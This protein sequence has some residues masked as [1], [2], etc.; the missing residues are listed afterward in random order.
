MEAQYTH[1]VLICA[2]GGCVSSACADVRDAARA[3][4]TEMGLEASVPVDE[5]GCMGLCAIG[6]VMLI[7]P[8]RTFY[9]GLNAQKAAEIIEKHVGGG[10]VVEKYTYFD[11]LKLRHIPC[12]DEIDFY[13]DQVR[14]ALRNCGIMPFGDIEAYIARDG[15]KAL[16]QALTGKTPQDVIDIVK[17]SGLRGRGGAG[18]PT[19]LKWQTAH[20]AR[21][22]TKY[23]VCNA[24]EGDP[25]AFMDRSIL[26]GDPHTVL[27]GML[28]AGYASGARH[29][30]VYV[31]AEYPI[32]I[33]RLT[34]A[35]EQARALGLLG[36]DLFG[37]GFSFDV[38]IRIGAGAFVC[39]EETALMA[40]IESQRG[41]PRQ[42]PPYPSQEGLYGC[43]TIINNVETLAVVPDIV[44]EGAD[45]FAQYGTEQ[46]KGTK[47]FAL[48]GDIVNTGLIEVPIG[49]PIGD[50]IFKIGGGM[51]DKKR[52][53]A[54]QIGGPSGGCLTEDMLNTPTDYETLAERGAIMGSG[55]IIAMNEDACMVDTAR[56]FM[57]F[58]QDESCGKCVACRVGTKRMLEI[59]TRITRG[60][61]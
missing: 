54:V 5:T 12:I 36:K 33:E 57:D 39:G 46:S 50:I 55:G 40:S 15:Y 20:D 1:R 17:A 60:E 19:G 41:E 53:K 48:A 26:E 52:F 37:S 45:W 51:R 25:G 21:G 44:L 43:P 30:Y 13:R 56:F 34:R 58:I 42:K 24:D 4:V 29:G 31:R 35:I 10:Q 2:G 61:G 7:L 9:V 22:D 23:V 32:A 11:P 38:D 18:F 47:V 28:L 49:M 16:G 14:I 8:D 27:E 3:K 59:L 6:P